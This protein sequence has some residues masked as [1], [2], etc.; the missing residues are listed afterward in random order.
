MSV[1]FC[2]CFDFLLFHR[3]LTFYWHDFSPDYGDVDLKA[4]QK[5]LA[6]KPRTWAEYV[7]DTDWSKILN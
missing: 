4:S 1:F 3:S 5:D 7:K 6:R 2:P